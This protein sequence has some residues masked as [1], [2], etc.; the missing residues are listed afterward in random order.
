MKPA[1]LHLRYN[2]DGIISDGQ[3][4]YRHGNAID[5]ADG[6]RNG[7]YAEWSWDGTTLAAGNCRYGMSPLF[8]YSGKDEF[9]ISNSIPKILECGA[10]NE[11]D[12]DAMAVFIR[13]HTFLGEDTPFKQIRAM[14]T[15]AK[16][17]WSNGRLNLTH[18]SH[19]PKLQNLKHSEVVDGIIELFAQAIK[20]RLPQ[21][22]D[23]CVPLTGGKDSRHILLE[24][25][26]QSAF[27]KACVTANF[28]KPLTNEDS[29]I[30]QLLA[31]RLG[32]PHI[33][34]P[35]VGFGITCEKRKNLHTNFCTLDHG[36]A[37]PLVDFLQANTAVSYDGIGLDVFFNTIWYS[38]KRA[39]LYQKGAF[40]ALA[41]DLLGD[42][43][44][45]LSIILDKEAYKRFNR[46]RAITRL[47]EE[48][49]LHADKPHP[50]AAFQFWSRTRRTTSTF[51]FGLQHTIPLVH[52]PFLDNDLF[53]FVSSC[54]DHSRIAVHANVLSKAY[55][56]FD[57]FPYTSTQISP[58]P[59]SWQVRRTLIHVLINLLSILKKDSLIRTG[60]I[61]SRFLKGSLTGRNSDFKWLQ[62][63]LINHINQMENYKFI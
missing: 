5:Q 15:N 9:C 42:S 20:R 37:L 61:Y 57:E 58:P 25:V 41:S 49:K 4:S 3:E 63:L 21:T 47:V 60:S 26:R 36:W 45:A 40:E 44:K 31:S 2:P 38:D 43:E 18:E 34:L 59:N 50:I 12:N 32:L 7:V 28:P 53:D 51:T 14:P 54:N 6:S 29:E 22:D 56:E 48:L 62:P 46:A 8:Y 52:T 30:A 24:L 11:W 35:P 27:P 1:F 16:L 39:R 19:T 23:F 33:V 55:P 10:P 17:T 13:R